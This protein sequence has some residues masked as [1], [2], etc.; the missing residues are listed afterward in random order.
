MTAVLR[1]IERSDPENR[2]GPSVPVAAGDRE[3][4]AF[5]RGLA[6]RAQLA[7]PL[8][9]DGVCSLVAPSSPAAYGLA[10]MRTLDAV[11]TRPLVFHPK[12]SAETSFDE[13]WL[14][15]LLRCLEAGDES[16]ARLLIGR[17]AGRLGQRTVGWLALGLA[18]RLD[19]IGLD[20]A[21]LEPF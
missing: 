8:S 9:L 12:G 7:P 17:R 1:R 3:L 6:R 2:F 19:A 10:L 15:R 11:A 14:V 18:E 21:R 16:S 5:L 4:L 20:E 13:A